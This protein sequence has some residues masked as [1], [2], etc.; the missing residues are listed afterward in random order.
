MMMMPPRPSSSRSSRLSTDRCWIEMLGRTPRITPRPGGGRRGGGLADVAVQRTHWSQQAGPGTGRGLRPLLRA[1][2]GRGAGRW[3]CLGL[4]LVLRTPRLRLR[5][6]RVRPGDVPE[7][8]RRHEDE[9][10]AHDEPR[11][12]GAQPAPD[13]VTVSGNR[14]LRLGR[15][16]W[17]RADGPEP[18]QMATEGR[19]LACERES[20]SQKVVMAPIT[21]GIPPSYYPPNEDDDED[22]DD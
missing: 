18:S 17:R 9:G 3:H 7:D 19:F 8:L 11:V 5:P 15:D 21:Q 13:L 14:E 6:V 2:A 22:D 10:H 16:C 4:T 20:T 12:P 1:W